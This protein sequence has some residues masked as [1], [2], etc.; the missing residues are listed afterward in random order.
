[1]KLSPQIEIMRDAISVFFTLVNVNVKPDMALALL[2][3]F[4]SSNFAAD[5]VKVCMQ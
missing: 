5:Q 3:Y 1:M 4:V 2:N